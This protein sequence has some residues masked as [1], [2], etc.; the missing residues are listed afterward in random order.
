MCKET[1]N[2]RKK[3]NIKKVTTVSKSATNK[4]ALE[5]KHYNLKLITKLSNQFPT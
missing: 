1:L 4:T 3:N 2:K 5:L